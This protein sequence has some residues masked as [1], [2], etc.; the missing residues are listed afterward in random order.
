MQV[1][2]TH[3][4]YTYTSRQGRSSA[5]CHCTSCQTKSQHMDVIFSENTARRRMT[6]G[7]A[8]RLLCSAELSTSQVLRAKQLQC[9][10]NLLSDG[11]SYKTSRIIC[12]PLPPSHPQHLKL[13]QLSPSLHQLVTGDDNP[14][15][16]NR[17]WGV[18]KMDVCISS[19]PVNPTTLHADLSSQGFS[20]LSHKLLKL[21]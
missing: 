6:K 20:H 10:T 3:A 7:A 16:S 15:M 2:R 18:R 13:H 9:G 11:S 17:L 19:I 5:P 8:L 1:W 4:A 12:I 21:P 14:S